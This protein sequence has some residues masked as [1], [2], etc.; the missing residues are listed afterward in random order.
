[1]FL[2]TLV[3]F[4]LAVAGCI[5]HSCCDECR[6]AGA[7]ATVTD[8]R[9]VFTFESLVRHP[10]CTFYLINLSRISRIRLSFLDYLCPHEISIRQHKYAQLSLRYLFMEN[11]S[12]RR[13]QQSLKW[14]LQAWHMT[15][16]L[17][18][19]ADR[20]CGYRRP[21]WPK[22]PWYCTPEWRFIYRRL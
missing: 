13:S 12:E 14:H 18:C 4:G 1:M 21:L 3:T 8:Q 17:I 7:T 20:W 9:W 2:V 19:V 16:L 22:T 6:Q 10:L 5:S 15:N 11:L